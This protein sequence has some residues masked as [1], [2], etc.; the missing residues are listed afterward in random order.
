[1]TPTATDSNRPLR[2]PDWIRTSIYSV[3]DDGFGGR[4]GTGAG[5]PRSEQRWTSAMLLGTGLVHSV[6]V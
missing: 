6:E 1:M 2:A 3:T 5:L 4:S